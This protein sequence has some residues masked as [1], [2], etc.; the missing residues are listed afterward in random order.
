MNKIIS[1][2][3]TLVHYYQ[4][5]N[6]LQLAVASHVTMETLY[7]TIFIRSSDREIYYVC[8]I[9][10]ILLVYLFATNFVALL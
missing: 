9:I 4:L 2:V 8:L 10:M 3:H 7:I 6:R 5:L 1:Q